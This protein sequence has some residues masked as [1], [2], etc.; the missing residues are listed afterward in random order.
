MPK[1]CASGSG[2]PPLLPVIRPEEGN[3]M[4]SKIHFAK[5]EAEIEAQ[6]IAVEAMLIR[7][8]AAEDRSS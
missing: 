8:E 5:R 2:N 7:A 6:R 1:E 3:G 4:Y